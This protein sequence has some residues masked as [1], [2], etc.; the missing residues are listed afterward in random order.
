MAK[1]SY[2][3]V[4]LQTTRTLE[5]AGETFSQVFD[6]RKGRGAV[7]NI[8]GRYETDRRVAFDDGWGAGEEEENGEPAALHTIVTEEVAKSIISRNKS[9]DLP[10]NVSLNPY[11]GCEHGCVYCFARP[12]HAYL[13]LSPGLDFESRIFAKMNAPELLRKELAKPSYIAETITVGI[14][15]DAYQPCERELQI[16][17]RVLQVL[18]ECRH[19]AALITK[20]SLI[21]RDVDILA[22]MAS[23]R[24]VIAAVT[25][26][27][28]DP[29]LAR[30]LEPRA[31]T[32]TRRLRVI[33]T[34]ADAGIPVSVSIAPIIPF[35]NE[36]ELESIVAAA[37]EAGARRA[38]YTVL[39]LPWE[40]NPLF[41]QWLLTHFPERANRVMNRIREMR[42]GKDND[43]DFATRMRGEGVWADLIRQRFDKA[44][45]RSAM[46]Q[47]GWFDMLDASQFVP[48]ARPPKISVSGQFDLF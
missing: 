4:P 8:Q 11:R 10:F 43:S 27:T 7:S 46:H 35:V 14:N 22:A 20:S 41:Q 29:A 16:T 6:A 23:R 48:P 40:V 24:Q 2:R 47:R 32:P 13:G 15:T 28:L 25:I 9:P 39:R 5:T 18:D 19:P 21:E 36:P 31:A 42:G 17:R 1:S 30:K 33:R 37:A 3:P 34:L 38:G 45:Q 12:T 44:V 26:A